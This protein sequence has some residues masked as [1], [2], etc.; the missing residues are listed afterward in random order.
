MNHSKATNM[1]Q[2]R[3]CEE[4]GARTD[5]KL[6]TA[7][8]GADGSG[9]E[10]NKTENS[11][12][13][14]FREKTVLS[15]PVG[16][17]SASYE[18]LHYGIELAVLLV[19][20]TIVGIEIWYF[21]RRK[22]N[23]GGKPSSANLQSK[24]EKIDDVIGYNPPTEPNDL[25][26]GEMPWQTSC[27]NCKHL[28]SENEDLKSKNS[29][30][31]EENS[32]L[33]LR[34]PGSLSKNQ[35]VGA[36][37]KQMEEREEKRISG[38]EAN[39][40]RMDSEIAA[41]ESELNEEK[42]KVEELR[43]KIR[44]CDR[45][46][47]ERFSKELA[48]KDAEISSARAE[49]QR[50]RDDGESALRVEKERSRREL[51]A[52]A[53]KHAEETASLRFVHKQEI[54]SKESEISSA[55]AEVQRV[56]DEG[57]SALRA[58]KERSRCELAAV[59]QKH[60]EETATLK[61]THKREISVKDAEIIRIEKACS[62]MLSRF[63]PD[64]SGGDEELVPIF[65]AWVLE[66]RDS[67]NVSAP[68]MGMLSQLFAWKVAVVSKMSLKD[69]CEALFGFSRH[70]FRWC[71]MQC[72]TPAEART[73]AVKFSEAFNASVLPIV[74]ANYKIFVPEVE[75]S[76]FAKQMKPSLNGAKVGTVLRLETWG[77]ED[78]TGR[79]LKC[80]DVVLR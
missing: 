17:N 37:R 61:A 46:A 48:V 53:Q 42:R 7:A 47:E 72:K 35:D 33:K 54:A 80:A 27:S 76:Y 70:F 69:Q 38:L 68:V 78:A 2:S 5:Q 50:V 59:A 57:E 51:A 31:T 19:A 3:S 67:E 60:A 26:G 56:R 30:L 52:A 12:K 4:G 43:E 73:L 22:R 32:R 45:D 39:L 66:M 71:E 29:Q 13:S 55:R 14:H 44:T 62:G 34:T 20:V 75:V 10:G 49:V 6:D 23:A 16:E 1:N 63:W 41:K 58:E 21:L 9:T 65:N 77:I 25:G 74:G 79:C 64:A 18:L 8:L 15:Y 36:I 24:E 40:R 28:I 11:E